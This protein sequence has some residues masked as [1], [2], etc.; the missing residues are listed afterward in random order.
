MVVPAPVVIIEDIQGEPGVY[1]GL[2][3]FLSYFLR[4]V[5]LIDHVGSLS[6]FE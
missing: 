4:N 3:H 5:Y 1:T 6:F 2:F